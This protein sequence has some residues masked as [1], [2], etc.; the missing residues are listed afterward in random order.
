MAATGI[1]EVGTIGERAGVPVE[2][3]QWGWYC[4]FSPAID[5]GLRASG[6][7]TSFEKAR[8]DFAEAWAA[9]LPR[10]LEA[11]FEGYRRQRAWKYE[12][13]ETAFKLPTQVAE[14]R[15]QCFCGAP[16]D[17]VTMDRHV[18]AAHMA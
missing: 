8:P 7:A 5:R 13:Q 3:D 10:C 9:Y 4:G 18:I 11:D 14:L 2:V 6:T 16:I 17:L 12:M 15:S 1:S